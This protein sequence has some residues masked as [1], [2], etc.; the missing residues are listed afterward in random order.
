MRAISALEE[1]ITT[2]SSNSHA[3]A[4]FVAGGTG[5]TQPAAAGVGVRLNTAML[6]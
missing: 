3:G 1:I 5:S 6:W 4:V 2:M